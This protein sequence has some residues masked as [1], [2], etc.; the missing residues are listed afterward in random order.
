MITTQDRFNAAKAYLALSEVSADTKAATLAEKAQRADEAAQALRLINVITT[1]GGWVQT[2]DLKAIEWAFG[3]KIVEEKP[4]PTEEQIRAIL[5]S[6][7]TSYWLK[8]AI[9]SLDSRDCLDAARDA[10]TLAWI[11]SARA[12]E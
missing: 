3:R 10:D 11:A 9:R 8:D 12:G 7:C 2:A 4:T 1:N 6:P 5:E